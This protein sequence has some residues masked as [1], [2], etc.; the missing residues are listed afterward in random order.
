MQPSSDTQVFTQKPVEALRTFVKR[1]LVVEFPSAH[2]D[3]HLPDTGLV[4]AFP[5][6]GSCRLEDGRDVPRAALTGLYDRIRHHAHSQRNAIV[7]TLFTTMGAAA[8]VRHPLDELTNTTVGLDEL[9]DNAP[10]LAHLEEQLVEA[11]NHSRRVQ[12]VEDFLLARASTAQPD[13]LVTAAVHWIEHASPD[14]RIEELVRHIGL[15]QSAL[16]RRFRRHVGVS[17]K[18]FAALVRLKTILR[19]HAYGHDFTSIAHAAS[20]FDQSHFTHDFKR[21]TGL[22]PESYFAH[23]ATG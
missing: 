10:A 22:A 23:A 7:L 21:V 1:F 8:F 3:S 6:R 14:A 18:K 5:F 2:D 4:A 9:F 19:L 12:R 13:P 20:Y 11:P 15:S 16:E 17:P